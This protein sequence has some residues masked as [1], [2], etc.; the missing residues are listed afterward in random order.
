M[1]TSTYPAKLLTTLCLILFLCSCSSRPVSFNAAAKKL[2]NRLLREVQIKS[3]LTSPKIKQIV[4]DDFTDE[5]TGELVA[6]GTQ[7]E[8][9]IF[10]VAERKFTSF[11]LSKMDTK[12]IRQADYLINGVISFEQYKRKRKAKYYHIHASATDL[13]TGKIIASASAWIKN[14][15]LDYT[16]E[17]GYNEAPMYMTDKRHQSKVRTARSVSGVQADSEY[18]DSLETNAL[19][20]EGFNAFRERDYRETIH[21]LTEAST[22]SDGQVMKTYSGLYQAYLKEGELDLAEEAFGKLLDISVESNNFSIKLLFQ[23]NST[24]FISDKKLRKRY[25]IW[26]RQISKFFKKN[27][28]CARIVGHSSNTGAEEYNNRLSKQR[29]GAVQNHMKSYDKLVKQ[30]TETIG[31][32]FRENIRGLGTDDG[33]DSI[34]RRVEFKIIDCADLS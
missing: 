18:Y 14:K 19:I 4:V 2:A 6:A 22:R 26:I 27:N 21:M 30:K 10:S 25:Q 29:A 16:P 31:M 7:I 33:R 23:V 1:H 8:N 24:Q 9:I 13:K 11:S 34:D 15:D 12:N 28:M 20:A 3:L 32:G 17:K 5:D